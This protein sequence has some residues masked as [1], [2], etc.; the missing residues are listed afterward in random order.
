MTTTSVMKTKAMLMMVAIAAKRKLSY[1]T[2]RKEVSSA[3]KNDDSIDFY[4]GD[5]GKRTVEDHIDYDFNDAYNEN[6]M[7]LD[8]FI[9]VPSCSRKMISTPVTR[10][11][12]KNQDGTHPVLNISAKYRW[13]L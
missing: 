13:W 4:K 8:R 9:D 12:S 11:I 7:K 10:H 6:N 1:S 5:I 2:R 3:L